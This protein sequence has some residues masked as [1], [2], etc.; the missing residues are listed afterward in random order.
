MQTTVMSLRTST[1]LVKRPI[2]NIL[3]T[4]IE[5]VSRTESEI[6][7]NEVWPY[8]ANVPSLNR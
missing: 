7:V 2:R 4:T 3:D 5:I 1:K 8:Y 6:E